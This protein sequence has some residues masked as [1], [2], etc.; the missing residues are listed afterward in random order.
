MKTTLT[1]LPILFSSLTAI[2]CVV[3]DD[4]LS[5][6][7]AEVRGAET[8][9]VRA[10]RR[11]CSGPYCGGYI[12]HVD[13]WSITGCADGTDVQDM[14]CYVATFD[15]GAM[16]LTPDEERDMER[17]AAAGRLV[18]EGIMRP[19]DAGRGNVGQIEVLV[20][21]PDIDGWF[22]DVNGWFPNVNGWR[23]ERTGY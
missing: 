14:S 3:D 13:H 2:G 17:L 21:Y 10:D 16:K 7:H 19:Y 18:V 20:A 22:P 6:S 11:S 8:Y 23:V 5:E 12:A 15:W 9:R 1:I 4:M